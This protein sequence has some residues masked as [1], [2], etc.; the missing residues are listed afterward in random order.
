MEYFN[1]ATI[2]DDTRSL[3]LNNE[4]IE[5]ALNYIFTNDCARSAIQCWVSNT[6]NN[7]SV[8]KVALVLGDSQISFNVL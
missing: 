7:G 6:L 2:L 8:G 1:N 4:V 5:A 3:Y